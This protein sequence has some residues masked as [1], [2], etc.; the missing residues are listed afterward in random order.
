MEFETALA[1]AEDLF[2]QGM[3]RSLNNLESEIFLRSWQRQTYAVMAE[4]LDYSDNHLREVGA[5]L[6]QALGQALGEEVNKNNF[7]SALLRHLC[8]RQQTQPQ[9]VPDRLVDPTCLGREPEFAQMDDWIRT[10]SRIILIYGEGGLGKTTLVRK[11][12]DAWGYVPQLHVWMGTEPNQLTTAE[13]LVEEWLQGQFQEEAGRDFTLN[14]IRL[15]R[16]LSDPACRAG[17]LIDNLEAA[18]DEES[19]FLSSCRTYGQ[20]LEMLSEPSLNAVTFLV[21]R[22]RLRESRVAFERLHL[23]G[24]PLRAW[25]QHFAK[26]G[27]PQDSP[28]IAQ[29][30][31]AWGGNA[32]AMTILASTIRLDFGG[33][34][35]GAWQAENRAFLQSGEL[36]DLVSSQFDRLQQ[37][38][39]DAYRLLCRLGCHRYQ[40]VS[41]VPFEAVDCLLWDVANLPRRRSIIQA[42]QDRSLLECRANRKFWLHPMMRTEAIARLREDRSAWEMTHRRIAEFWLTYVDRINTV[43]EAL[44]TLES[45]FHY[46]EI[47]DYHQAAEVLVTLKRSRWGGEMQLGW[48]FYRLGVFQQITDAIVRVA[49]HLVPDERLGRLYNLCGYIHR[50]SGDIRRS[51]RYHQRALQIARHECIEDLKL[52][53]FFNLGLCLRDLWHVD[54]ALTLFRQTQDLAAALQSDGY[55]IYSTCCLAYL[56]SCQGKLTE[57]QTQLAQFTIEQLEESA[58]KWGQ[59]YSLLFLG[60]TYRNLRDLDR[61]QQFYQKTIDHAQDHQFTQI[62]AKALHGLAQVYR[63]NRKYDRA[64]EHHQMAIDLLSK[65]GARCDLAEAYVQLG[66]TYRQL[67]QISQAIQ[68][69]DRAIVLFQEIDA[70]RRVAWVRQMFDEA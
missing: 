15:R 42:L 58:S 17:I 31:D 51:I 55:W 25:Q 48:L 68:C 37:K 66:L 6:F 1:L 23:E 16:K 57:A 20:L 50:L 52:S 29:M 2:L 41:H 45:Y 28:A 60:N 4:E 7:R 40:D 12:L 70:L 46:C 61:A 5:T 35:E 36:Q 34:V 24:L 27:L 32:T 39:P 11:Y 67:Q 21:S 69:R 13:S 10:G 63:S 59:G 38:H 18:L 43:E 19:R 9:T 56:Y 49:P 30:W 54:T 3:G 47:G 8:T 65:L 14:L 22:V 33:D 62:R 44:Q 64:L 53:A 26:S